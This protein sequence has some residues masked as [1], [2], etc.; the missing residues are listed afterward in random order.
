[1]ECGRLS[2]TS[3]HASGS[4]RWI[5]ATSPGGSPH[6][7][8][9]K[10][11][12]RTSWQKPW[13]LRIAIAS[14]TRRRRTLNF[15]KISCVRAEYL[16]SSVLALFLSAG[17]VPE[18]TNAT[19][20]PD[21]AAIGNA[22][23]VLPGYSPVRLTG[24]RVELAPGRAYQWDNSL[25]PVRIDSRD[26]ELVGPMTIVIREAGVYKPVTAATFKVTAEAADHVELIT[27]GTVGDQLTVEAR[28]RIEYDGMAIV[29]LVITPH[30]PV[31]IDAMELV[32]PVARTP[33][34]RL[35]G[36]APETIYQYVKQI[37]FPL[38]EDLPYK[39]TI[40]FTGSGKA[41]WL[42]TD[43]PAIPSRSSRWPTSLVCDG[44]HV[45]LRQPLL[46]KLDLSIPLTL[47][48]AFLATPVRVLPPTF[49]EDRVVPGLSADDASFGNR[50]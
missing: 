7:F 22:E 2:A 48:F 46:A 14:R 49:R 33:E 3:R 50:H 43:E 30:R 19:A 5:R 39:S 6:S 1:M 21:G 34:M 36:F 24:R 32:A 9:E 17:M 25:L 27:T 35:L 23:I 28:T 4:I 20:A 12:L 45:D 40:G 8:A 42:L 38:C 10:W 26:T 37:V 13:S 41:F 29:D 11:S 47:R 16:I 18:P 44:D 15:T 31:H